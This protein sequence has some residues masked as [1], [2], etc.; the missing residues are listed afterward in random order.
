MNKNNL[1]IEPVISMKP[2][3]MALMLLAGLLPTAAAL[4]LAMAGGLPEGVVSPGAG[5]TAQPYDLA[6]AVLIKGLLFAVSLVIAVLC[7]LQFKETG[8]IVKPVLAAPILAGGIMS[9][10][11]VFTQ[12][13]K[14]PNQVPPENFVPLAQVIIDNLTYLYL[15][16]LP[17]F[18]I[19]LDTIRGKQNKDRATQWAVGITVTLVIV[20]LWIFQALSQSAAAQEFLLRGPFSSVF[21]RWLPLGL[22]VFFAVFV[23][24]TYHRMHPSIFVQTVWLACLPLALGS[25]H[26]ALTGENGWGWNYLA[27]HLAKLVA[28]MLLAAGLILEYRWTYRAISENN[29][30]LRDQL[31]MS[32]QLTENNRNQERLLDCVMEH[33]DQPVCFFDN[34]MRILKANPASARLA[35]AASAR[36]LVGQTASQA[37]PGNIPGLLAK[38]VREALANR[39]VKGSADTFSEGDQLRWLFRVLSDDQGKVVGVV[40]LGFNKTQGA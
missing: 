26:L 36:A 14:L 20:S 22:V 33:M 34:T 38:G 4:V 12:Y 11:Q 31:F 28:Y 21:F 35:S 8:R 23:L 13:F 39:E 15:C 3:Q 5:I 27:G 9:L 2:L 6:A 19:M 25:L 10:V 40:A 18:F 17:T 7:F 24:P 32:S 30:D 16:L 29:R 37:F 1:Q